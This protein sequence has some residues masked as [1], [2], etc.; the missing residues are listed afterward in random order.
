MHTTSTAITEDNSW[1]IRSGYQAIKHT[2]ILLPDATKH[3][4]ILLCPVLGALSKYDRRSHLFSLGECFNYRVASSLTTSVQ[5]SVQSSLLYAEDSSFS[6]RRRG[7][8]IVLCSSLGDRVLLYRNPGF[9]VTPSLF[10]FFFSFFLFKTSR[11][12]Q[13]YSRSL[14][15][16]FNSLRHRRFDTQYFNCC[17]VIHLAV[18]SR[19]EWGCETISRRLGAKFLRAQVH[20]SGRQWT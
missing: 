5:M 20:T 9:Q 18:P 4:T 3:V 11:V 14:S 13:H 1:E 8:K 19:A 10:F 12:R 15:H 2:V 16:F 6:R 7:K 17:R